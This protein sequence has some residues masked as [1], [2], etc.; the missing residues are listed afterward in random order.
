M[1]EIEVRNPAH[2]CKGVKAL[3]L[4]GVRVERLPL[5]APGTTGRVTAVLGDARRRFP[6]GDMQEGERNDDPFWN[7]RLARRHRRRL[8]E[9]QRPAADAGAGA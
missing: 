1:Y 9:S 7:G 3:Y 2:V 6:G 4:D 8:H 5:L